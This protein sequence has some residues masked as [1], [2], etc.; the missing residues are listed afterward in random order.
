LFAVG[1]LLAVDVQPTLVEKTGEVN[2]KGASGLVGGQFHFRSIPKVAGVA[3]PIGVTDT[4]ERN[5][6]MSTE[7]QFAN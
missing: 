3:L 7:V 1:D 2:M 5:A 4:D 6:M